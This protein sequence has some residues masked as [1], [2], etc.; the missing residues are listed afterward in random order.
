MRSQFYDAPGLGEG[1]LVEHCVNRIQVTAYMVAHSDSGLIYHLADGQLL[2]IDLGTR[3][4]KLTKANGFEYMGQTYE[5]SFKLFGGGD[6]GQ[7]AARAWLDAQHV[8]RYPEEP[9]WA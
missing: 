5:P 8:A 2:A 7:Q 9:L 3:S 6:Q 1:V 4:A